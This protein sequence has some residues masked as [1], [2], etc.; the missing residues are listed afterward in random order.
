MFR[1]G[2]L[3]ITALEESDLEF[4]K[5]LRNDPDTWK[6][7][8]DIQMLTTKGQE[9]WYKSLLGDQKR[10]YFIV[11]EYTG[12]QKIGLIRCDEV[13]QL[14]RSIRVGADV[15]KKE[16]GKGH[17]T[18]IYKLLLDYCFNYLNMHRV[19]LE[20]LASNH[21]AIKLYENAGFRHEGVKREAIF[22]NG[23]YVDYLVMSILESE[24][25]RVSANTD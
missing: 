1:H 15:V 20:V 19:W 22:R 14:N 10:K 4:C 12:G 16:R 8:T 17:G 7:L 25:E 5:H 24:H 18:R 9:N 6:Q 11:R 21:I 13:D 3:Y 2:D 23:K